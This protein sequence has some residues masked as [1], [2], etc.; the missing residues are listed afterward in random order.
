M[1]S[2]GNCDC[3]CPQSETVLVP[4]S[5]GDPG[6]N[7]TNGVNGINAFT[8]LNQE[9]A[10]VPANTSTPTTYTVGD[11]SWAAIG[12]TVVF[13]GPTDTDVSHYTVISKPSS[14]SIEL[15]WLDYPGDV[16]ATT[17]IADGTQLS[18]SGIL[19]DVLSTVVISFPILLTSLD[20]PADLVTD[21]IMPFAATIVSWQL[22]TEVVATSGGTADADIE[23]QIGAAAVTGSSVTITQADFSAIGKV[24]AGGTITA[25]N[26]IAAGGT[27]SIV[28][29]ESAVNFTAGKVNAY[30]A[31]QIE[32]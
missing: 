5:Q 22:V 25:G 3:P 4:G 30:V 14:T 6:E 16:A 7:G 27:F 19:P 29:T 11:S 13:G 12:Q 24:K 20:T 18:P 23:L 21:F 32:S 2:A 15:Q 1:S 26:T 8:Y 10:T 17:A 31:F 9:D 28:C